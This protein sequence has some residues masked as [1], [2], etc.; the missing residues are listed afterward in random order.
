M[1]TILGSTVQCPPNN[2]E[3]NNLEKKHIICQ[4]KVFSNVHV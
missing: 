1:E 4:L 2:F 3:N